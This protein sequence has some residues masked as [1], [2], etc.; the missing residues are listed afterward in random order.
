M[1]LVMSKCIQLP[2]NTVY[3]S[4]SKQ[5]SDFYEIAKVLSDRL[6]SWLDAKQF[7]SINNLLYKV[8]KSDNTAQVLISTDSTDAVQSH[9]FWQH[10]T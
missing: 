9:S 6:L 4:I 7:C 10:L 5:I 3:D 1:I 2:K 8:F